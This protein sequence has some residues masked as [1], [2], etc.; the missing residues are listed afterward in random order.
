MLGVES[1]VRARE[2][3]KMPNRTIL[4]VA[5]KN[6]VAK[7]ITPILSHG[8]F[9][10]R[11]GYEKYCPLYCFD[12]EFRGR[13]RSHVVTSVMGH[14]MSTDFE[15]PFKKWNS[16]TPEQ[17]FTA[18]IVEFVPEK[19]RNL[20]RQLKKEAQNCDTII[21]WLDCDREGEA[22]ASEVVNVCCSG[23]RRNLTILRAHFSAVN[24]VEVRRAMAS[25]RNL[26]Q[27]IVSAVKARQEIDLRLGAL[28]TRWQTKL[29]QQTYALNVIS[30][31]PCQFPTLGFVVDRFT[32]I[33]NFEQEM[34][35]NIQCEYGD[36]NDK[37]DGV[38]FCEF[39]WKRA[40]PGLFNRACAT[41]LLETCVEN[42]VA[43]VTKVYKNATRKYKPLPLATT[44]LG[45]CMSKW[46]R[47][48]AKR[49]LDAAEKLYQKGYISYPRTETEIFRPE[50]DFQAILQEQ[51]RSDVWGNYAAELLQPQHFVRP[52]MASETTSASPYS[53]SQV[54]G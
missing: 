12:S 28:F 15:Q 26:N 11:S 41:M 50:F 49:A 22:I 30:Y 16:C 40:T 51:T 2:Q 4:H 17:L 42:P 39:S 52:R 44:T 25:L 9:Q 1:P 18:P 8:H 14:L 13:R 20:E 35:W 23:A 21:L 45:I 33:E 27:N 54:C 38:N 36:P 32:R 10:T 46:R 48:S 5:E 19:F 7:S 43:R 53:S 31:G 3:S 29:L 47:I 34:F 37:Q 6:S 24:A